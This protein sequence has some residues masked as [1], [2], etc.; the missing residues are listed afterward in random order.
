MKKDN[1]I[2][3]GMLAVAIIGSGYLYGDKIAN[4]FG[5]NT[6]KPKAQVEDVVDDTNEK[7]SKSA[8]NQQ[9]QPS[10]Q[11]GPSLVGNSDRSNELWAYDLSDVMKNPSDP[12]RNKMLNIEYAPNGSGQTIKV[13]D[14]VNIV[15]GRT[16]FCY[17]IPNGDIIFEG[18]NV[19][20]GSPK[21]P[22]VYFV[23]H[24]NGD[25]FT[26]YHAEIPKIN[27]AYDGNR[28]E[29]L[30]YAALDMGY[31]ELSEHPERKRRNMK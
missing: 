11:S 25:T 9:Q 22:R 3:A 24:V 15:F 6:S 2:I 23:F 20:N 14:I 5:I 28:S 13:I 17:G 19:L 18:I 1:L 8:P 31:K 26:L 29:Q 10:V 7:Q 16:W 12:N 30:W 4:K 21:D 27:K